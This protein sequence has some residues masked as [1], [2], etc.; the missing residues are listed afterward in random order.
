M[1]RVDEILRIFLPPVPT[2]LPACAQY[3]LLYA[4]IVA[5]RGDG[6]GATAIAV[7]VASSP[8]RGQL[9]LQLSTNGESADAGHVV[10]VPSIMLC[11]LRLD[12]AMALGE[13]HHLEPRPCVWPGPEL[14]AGTPGHGTTCA[15]RQTSG[16]GLVCRL[17]R[18]AVEALEA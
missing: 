1:F 5:P 12:V 15:V 6:V 8:R 16:P 14:D 9:K 11:N 7:W 2:A 3:T 18:E 17:I 10:S 4:S 13:H